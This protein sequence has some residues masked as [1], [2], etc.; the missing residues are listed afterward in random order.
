TNVSFVNPE[1]KL[2]DF[3]VTF[4]HI[5]HSVSDTANLFI[6]TPVGNFYHG[7]DFKF[8]LTPHDGKKTDLQKIADAGKQGVLCLMSDAL[9][10][11]RKGVTPS[12]KDIGTE[13]EHA[14]TGCKGKV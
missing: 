13:F 12:E 7:S 3:S 2:A 9:G 8:D 5:T 10:S 6:K 1:V 4:V 14:I 11:E